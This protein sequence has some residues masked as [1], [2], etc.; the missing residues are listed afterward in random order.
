MELTYS[1]DL[2]G[3]ATLAVGAIVV[4]IA[5]LFIDQESS[6]LGATLTALAAFVGGFV[7][8]EFVT[9]A[10]DWEPVFGGLALGPAIVGGLIVGA[11]AGL[12]VHWAGGRYQGTARA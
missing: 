9:G 8:S 7:V 4:G 2:L 12:V 6:L 1:I 3:L 10:R 5:W 11:A